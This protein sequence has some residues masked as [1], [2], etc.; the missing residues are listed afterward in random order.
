MKRVRASNQA[1]GK[2]HLHGLVSF[3]CID[4]SLREEILG[5]MNSAEDLQQ[6]RNG[7]RHE[8]HVIDAELK[9]FLVKPKSQIED[10]ISAIRY[11]LPWHKGVRGW[12]QISL[13]KWYLSCLLSGSWIGNWCTTISENCAID[14]VFKC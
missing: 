2:I 6:D 12:V 1:T 13:D 5:R 11:W 9:R 3:Q 4:R 10:I 14:A 8:R 7:R